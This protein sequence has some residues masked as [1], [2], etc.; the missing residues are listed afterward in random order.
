MLQQPLEVGV[1]NGYRFGFIDGG[2][3]AADRMDSC[4]Q[5][6]AQATRHQRLRPESGVGK[7]HTG[8]E[9]EGNNSQ[10]G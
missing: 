10:G 4:R 6:Q 9:K 8:G 5:E 7:P 1:R 3:G 2:F